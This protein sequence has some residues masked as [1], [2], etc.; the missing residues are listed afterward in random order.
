MANVPTTKL[1]STNAAR[2]RARP[3]QEFAEKT[4]TVA[5]KPTEQCASV[6]TATPE[7]HKEL[8]SRSD[9]ALT[10]IVPQFKLASTE[11][12]SILARSHLA[13]STRC[14]KLIPITKLDVTALTTSEEI[15]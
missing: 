4:P 15:R 8:A 12:V 7:T 11:N 10:A 5:H 6:G 3:V 2:I 13:A 14:A 9:V 1:A